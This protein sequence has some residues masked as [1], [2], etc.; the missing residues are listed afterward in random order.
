MLKV[1]IK[2]HKLHSFSSAV[3]CGFF[4]MFVSF[5]IYA[6]VPGAN[7]RSAVA[8]HDWAGLIHSQVFLEDFH[9]YGVLHNMFPRR[10]AFAANSMLFSQDS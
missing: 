7:K 3:G 2:K 8:L 1:R 6:N 9:I 10:E 5:S 4:S